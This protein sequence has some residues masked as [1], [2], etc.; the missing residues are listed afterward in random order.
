MGLYDQQIRQRIEYDENVLSEAFAGMGDVVLGTRLAKTLSDRKILTKTAIDEILKYYHIPSQDLP[1][2]ITDIN[3]QL[4]Y[5]LRPSGIMRRAVKLSG[6]WYKDS[7]GAMLGVLRESGT[8]VALLPAGI[9]YTYFDPGTQKKVHL[10]RKTAAALDSEA[11]CFYKPLPLKSISVPDIVL[12]IFRCLS[13]SDFVLIAAAALT[14]AL[15]GLLIPKLSQIIYGNVVSGTDMTLFYAVF[16]FLASVS[17]TMLLINTAKTLLTERVETKMTLGAEAAG[18]MRILSLPA[19]FFRDY[20]SGELSNRIG[21]LNTLCTSLSQILLA[22]GLTSVFSL[23]Y[24]VQMV[25]FGPGLAVP[26]I[27][28]ILISVAF[29]AITSLAQVSYYKKTMELTAKESGLTY[30][31]VAGVQKLRL[32]GAENRAFAQWA[33]SYT[34]IAQRTYDP[35]AFLRLSGVFLSGISLI[36]TVVI[37]YFSIT[38]KI[39][40]ANYFAFNSAYAA[41]M[42]AF[43]SLVAMASG[44]AQIRPMMDMLRPIIKTQPEI[45]AN[46]EVV[47]NLPSGISIDHVS[48]RYSDNSPYIFN[49]LSLQIRSGEYLAIV[50]KTGCGKSTLVRLLLGFETPQKGAIYYGGKDLSS[51]DLKSLRRHIGSVMQNGRLFQGDIYSNIVITAPWLTLDEAWAAAEKAGMAEDIRQMPMGMSTMISEGSGGI[52]GGQKQRLMIARALAPNPKVL[53]FDEA[54]SALDNLTQKIVTDSLNNEKCTRI[55]IAHRLSTIRQCDRIV[56][57]ADGKIAEDGTYDQLI[58]KNGLFAELVERQR[59]DI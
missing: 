48:F 27:L 18:M 33:K 47:T 16:F 52:S 26:G 50:G 11:F 34:P 40:L 30:S 7:I 29:S 17:I 35:P 23:V 3:D 28:L 1:A 38:T 39:S 20:S 24:I 5:L 36:G 43:S 14:A 22:T 41:V 45:A 2:D 53:I 15:I 10:N 57:L 32:S 54:T 6:P 25:Q 42:G 58:A 37:Y 8:P 51:L 49:Q 31:L 13:K 55:V 21:Y 46:K 44:I 12:Y 56:V 59:L 19:D 4:E 9:G